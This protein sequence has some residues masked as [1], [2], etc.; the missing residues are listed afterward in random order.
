MQ[1]KG[2][3]ATLVERSRVNNRKTMVEKDERRSRSF[4]S[5]ARGI[6]F[7]SSVF[8]LNHELYLDLSLVSSISG[9]RLPR[10][11]HTRESRRLRGVRVR[12]AHT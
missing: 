6:S 4:R 5:S 11:V 9:A 2:L 3:L 8:F 10:A 1:R 7:P 12:T